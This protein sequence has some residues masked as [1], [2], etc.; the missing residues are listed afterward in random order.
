MPILNAGHTV[1]EHKTATRTRILAAFAEVLV[2]DGWD[3]AAVKA[4]AAQA[5]LTRTVIY[6]YFADK[7]EM[8]LAWSALEIDTFLKL[9][10]REITPLEDPRDKLE[11]VVELVLREFAGPHPVTPPVMSLI[12]NQTKL[13]FTSQL[14]ELEDVVFR[15]LSDG[16]RAG[17]FRLVDARSASRCILGCLD[18]HRQALADGGSVDEVISQV[19]P[20]VMGA[21]GAGPAGVAHPH[22][23]PTATGPDDNPPGTCSTEHGP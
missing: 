15:I 13:E 4:V 1:A 7:S 12:P 6:N 20:F 17:V 10:E 21:V 5:G 2:R 22:D 23:Q 3:G 16:E 18:P 9:I 8:L 14:N 11:T 19:V